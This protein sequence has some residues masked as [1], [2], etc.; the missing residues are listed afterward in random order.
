MKLNEVIEKRH[1]VRE[2][3]EKK[4]KWADILEAIDTASKVPF[5]G[6]INN[7]KFII[8]ENQE[9][10]NNITKH[11]QQ[12]W[13]A[14]AQIIIVVCSDETKLEKMYNER[15][16]IYSRQQAGAAIQN[17]LLKITD[18]GL[19]SCWV[20]AYSD[21]LIKQ[22]LKIPE[23]INIEAILPVGYGKGTIKKTRKAALENIINWEF[24]GITKKSSRT[25]DPTTW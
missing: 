22:V 3:K 4:V 25:K 8:V 11:C 2:F 13:I 5:A 18:L 1:S 17:F 16:K 19:S 10:K 12:T 9:L 7:L 6:N 14:D 20:G 15:G 23:F 21:E 24:W